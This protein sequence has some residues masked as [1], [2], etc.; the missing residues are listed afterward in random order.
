MFILFCPLRRALVIHQWGRENNLTS[1][2]AWQKLTEFQCYS[3]SNNPDHLLTTLGSHVQDFPV[4]QHQAA[5]VWMLL[6][7]AV[8]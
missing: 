8:W 1:F 7:A 3:L 2:V 6:Y 4:V 5:L